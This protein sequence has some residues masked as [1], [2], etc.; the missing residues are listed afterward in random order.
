MLLEFRFSQAVS[1][2]NSQIVTNPCNL[3]LLELFFR[4][5]VFLGKTPA[6]EEMGYRLPQLFL[7]LW[8]ILAQFKTFYA[9]TLFAPSNRGGYFL[10]TVRFATFSHRNITTHNISALSSHFIFQTNWHWKLLSVLPGTIV[11]GFVWETGDTAE[12]FCCSV[13]DISYSGPFISFKQI[14][15]GSCCCWSENT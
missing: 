5:Q 3:L 2:V 13:L 1:S 15:T 9:W 11:P 7:N 10:L 12:P 14:L 6:G 4:S 8:L